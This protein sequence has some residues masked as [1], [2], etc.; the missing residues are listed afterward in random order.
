[1]PQTAPAPPQ[2]AFLG[3]DASL[4]GRRWEGPDAAAM[5][6]TA[7]LAQQTGLPEQVCRILARASV[8]PE[9]AEA[10][11][12]PRLRD[13]MPD[14]SHLK[15]LDRAVEVMQ[16]HLGR[17]SRIAIFADYDVDGACSAALLHAWLAALQIRPTIYV[18]DR[19]DEGYGPNAP[20]MEALAADHRL[21]LCVD[22]GTLSHE[23][24]AA[25]RAAGA[26][27]LV[28]DHHL[29]GET[30]P[31]A[32]AVINPNRQDET[33]ELANLCAA[34]VVYLFLVALNRARR[35][36]GQPQ[37]DL[38]GLLDLVALATVADV[39]QLT[40]LNRA[41]VRQGLQVMSRRERAGLM[42][43]A[44]VAGL[45][46]PPSAYHLGYILGPRINAGGRVGQAD[47]GARLLT[48]A[49]P[50]EAT[51]LAQTL[52]TLNAERRD[53][54]AEV[55]AAAIAQAEAREAQGALVWAAGAG[56]HPGVVGIVAAR[57]KETFDRPAVVIGIDARG[58]GKGSGRSVPGV[59]LG[60]AIATCTAEGLLIKGGGHKMAAGLTVEEPRIG[61][62][63]AR[64]EAL[65]ARQGAGGGGP[66]SLRLDGLI[67]V[68]AATPELIEQ[69]ESAGP[70]GAGAPA[71]RFALGPVQV[72]NPRR[73]GERHLSLML[74]Q[75]GAS[76]KAIAFNAFDSRLGPALEKSG[77]AP[78][79][80]AGHL[81]IDDW[82]GR[83]RA[84]LRISD[85]ARVG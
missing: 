40:G 2:D 44:D 22:C 84:S 62:A 29:G 57:L 25:A 37:P 72:A 20:A 24:I 13:L 23:P 81:E 76:L 60:A 1:M 39:A 32:Q 61:E 4:T 49:D 12:T 58:E 64:L 66:G 52:D 27:V 18:P 35:Q 11:L 67:S 69:L 14:P 30:L 50:T 83:R 41:L 15:D 28:L 34:G 55:L 6:A 46:S 7:A 68:G 63:M 77:G 79:Y 16:A 65:L 42:A 53:I 36:A 21:I 80:V 33:S 17:G 48:T 31:P 70:F 47:L 54:E 10:Y 59:D 74:R 9:Q 75:D 43:L 19:I 82:G 26:E 38:M 45:K 73:V 8:P 71:P 78:V 3:I 5:R 56:W 85:A 51:A